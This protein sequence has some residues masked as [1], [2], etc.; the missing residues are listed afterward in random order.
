[1]FV[2][3]PEWRR[4]L[5]LQGRIRGSVVFTRASPGERIIADGG[6]GNMRFHLP[7]YTQPMCEFVTNIACSLL[8]FRRP[9]FVGCMNRVRSLLPRVAW[10][11]EEILKILVADFVGDK[12]RCLDKPV[13]FSDARP[14]DSSQSVPPPQSPRAVASQSADA[15]PSADP[16]RPTP[17]R[18]H[19]FASWS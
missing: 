5:R 16:A 9:Y 15:P 19:T 6:I 3:A 4:C 14:S 13:R 1:M 8:F 2:R 12:P 17:R 18:R 7:F 11:L 10:D